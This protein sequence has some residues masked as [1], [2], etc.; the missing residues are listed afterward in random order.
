VPAALFEARTGLPLVVC[1]AAL[2][3]ARSRGLLEADPIRL[4]PTLQ[5]Q[6][7]LNDLLEVFLVA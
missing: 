6:H 3:R 1:A 5:G 7:F 2:E 4:K